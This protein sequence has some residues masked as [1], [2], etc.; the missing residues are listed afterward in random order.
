MIVT[1]PSART[2]ARVLMIALALGAGAIPRSAAAADP[3][4]GLD[5]Y[6]ERVLADWDLPGVAVAVVRNDQLILARGYGVKELGR[7]QPIDENTLFEIG[8]TTKAFTAAALGILVDEGKISWD[9]PVVDHVPWFK[10]GD[11]WL[12]RNVSIR[13][14]MCHRSGVL[15]DW[16]MA[17]TIIDGEE[18]LRRMR[19]LDHTLPF[20]Q[21][22]QYSNLM[23]GLAGQVVA[24]VSGMSWGDFVKRRIFAPLGMTSSA[25]SAYDVWDARFVAPAFL[26]TAPAGRVGIDDA[27]GANV[28]MPHGHARNGRRKVLAW[29]SYDSAAGAG[30]IVSNV[31]DMSKWLRMHLNGG[32]LGETRVLQ[33]STVTE[34][35]SAQIPLPMSYFHFSDGK[36]S[37]AMGWDT[38]TF[39]GHRYVSHG[40]GIFGFPAYV[41]MVPDDGVG[42]VVLANGS[43]LNPYSPH[44][45][46]TAWIL[47]RLISLEGRDWRSEC[48][49]AADVYRQRHRAAEEKLQTS[50][51]LGT[52]PSLPL[53]AYA[54]EYANELAGT[55]RI[56][57]EDGDLVL[58]YPGDGAFSGTLEHWH[59]D[60]FRL[61]FDGG[62]GGAYTSSFVIFSID[63]YGVVSK[64]DAGPMG[65]FNRVPQS[66]DGR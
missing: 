64:L 38:T 18:A 44:Q 40:G 17:T 66:P 41:A 28:A 4:E 1:M 42:V 46:I 11:P 55:F 26:G 25:A 47:E 52:T 5:A 6:V 37:Y 57:V 58:R 62:D 19:L 45:Q 14:L 43:G 50:R 8:S 22:Y 60:V 2:A 7:K 33:E 34:L 59:H 21:Q 3:L 10:L 39:Q 16:Y 23:Y 30:S 56:D 61:Y 36:A 29:Q 53:E 35:H 27:P 15:D 9:D 32:T 48:L 13:D 20:R 65:E 49:A 31:T 51:H 54:G 63:Q 12:T 24:E